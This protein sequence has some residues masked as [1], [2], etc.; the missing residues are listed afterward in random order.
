VVLDEAQQQSSSGSGRELLLRTLPKIEYTAL[1]Q[2]RQQ[3]A[4][5]LNKSCGD[6][7]NDDGNNGDGGDATAAAASTVCRL[8][9]LPVIPDTLPS[10]VDD[11]LAANLFRLL[12]EIHVLEGV[13][14]C[15]DTG[16]EFPIKDGIPNMVLHA[17]EL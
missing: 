16:R 7:S 8:I 17:D 11:A 1:L 2:A 13:L 3:L 6:D 5:H 12:F 9:D 15:P 14:V 4:E 10:H